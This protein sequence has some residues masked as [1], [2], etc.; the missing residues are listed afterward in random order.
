VSQ[1]SELR[2]DLLRRARARGLEIDDI[3]EALEPGVASLRARLRVLADE[4][5]PD[6]TP[7][8]DRRESPR[9]S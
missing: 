6:D 2:E 8:P 4:L 3:A 9:S 1:P 7:P 5:R